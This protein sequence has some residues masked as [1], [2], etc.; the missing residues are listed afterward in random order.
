MSTFS[1]SKLE[2]FLLTMFPAELKT[3]STGAL[4]DGMQKSLRTAISRAG[5]CFT[6]RRHHSNGSAVDVTVG[7][8]RKLLNCSSTS[9]TMLS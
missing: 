7:L 2:R 5:K 4:V 6:S 8:L 9:A 3:R 1:G